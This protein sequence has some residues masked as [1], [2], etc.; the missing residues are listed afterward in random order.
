MANKS[1]LALAKK[2]LLSYNFRFYMGARTT[3]DVVKNMF[4]Q[5]RHKGNR[6]PYPL[7]GLRS[8]RLLCFSQFSQ[9]IKRSSYAM[10]DDKTY[11]DILRSPAKVRRKKGKCFTTPLASRLISRSPRAKLRPRTPRGGDA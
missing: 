1:I 9:D 8:V 10:T 3:Q 5:I 6:R 2:L 11:L 7:Q 4:S